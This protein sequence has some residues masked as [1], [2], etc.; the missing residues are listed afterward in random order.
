M[1]TLPQNFFVK[2]F[3]FSKWKLVL[4]NLNSQV[5]QRIC[6]G[7]KCFFSQAKQSRGYSRQKA[8]S[9]ERRIDFI[10]FKIDKRGKRGKDCFF[11]LKKTIFD[12]CKKKRPSWKQDRRIKTKRKTNFK[13]VFLYRL[14]CTNYIYLIFVSKKLL[15]KC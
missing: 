5:V 6:F 13:Q 7:D 14:Y 10:A 4:G 12:F 2:S 9:S 1:F 11:I 8:S 3:S 15:R